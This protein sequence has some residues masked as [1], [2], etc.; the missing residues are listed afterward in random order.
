MLLQILIHQPQQL[1]II[2]SKTPSWVWGLL[3]ALLLLGASQMKARRL[4]RARV[5]VTPLT[6]TLF[7]LLGM[8]SAFRASGQVGIAMALWLVACAIGMAGLLW[9]APS[10]PAGTRYDPASKTFHL[11]G[12]AIPMILIIGV[13]LTKYIAGIEQAMQPGLAHD[14]GYVWSLASLY[15]LLSGAFLA[16]GWRLWRLVRVSKKARPGGVALGKAT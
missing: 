15:G 7:S 8:L 5:A 14:A 11:P 10:A 4:P 1:A 3:A 9:L 2:A 12:S 13:F 16:R 6:M